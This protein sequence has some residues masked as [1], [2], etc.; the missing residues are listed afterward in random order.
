MKRTKET[1]MYLTTSSGAVVREHKFKA[2]IPP[3][4]FSSTIQDFVRSVFRYGSSLQR[5]SVRR[6]PNVTRFKLPLTSTSQLSSR[7]RLHLCL[8]HD[9]LNFL[10]VLVKHHLSVLSEASKKDQDIRHC[11][12][13]YVRY[14]L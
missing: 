3:I 7:C 4:W 5:Y 8:F 14:L 1:K 6:I 2:A 13:C 11:R 12:V 9:V 10:G